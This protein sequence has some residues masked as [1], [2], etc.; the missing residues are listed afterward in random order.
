MP[1]V[2]THYF[3]YLGF[4]LLFAALAVELALHRSSVDGATARRLFRID[5]LY[6]LAALIV[7]ATGLLKIFH[8]GKPPSY[9]GQNFIFHIKLTVFALIYLMS[10]Y[11]TVHFFKARKTSPD[12]T[13]TYPRAT[14]ILLRIEM[15]LLMILPLLGV[16]MARGYGYTG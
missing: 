1:T 4:G 5:G 7:L 11:P 2:L 6:G 14:G 3:H 12:A 9:Y 15:A 8:Y 16:M 13:V 10:L